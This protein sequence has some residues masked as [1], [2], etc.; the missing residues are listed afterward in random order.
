MRSVV[1]G[2]IQFTLLI[3]IYKYYMLCCLYS[4]DI[5]DKYS[6]IESN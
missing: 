5:L 2:R 1:I 4:I 6:I 3:D